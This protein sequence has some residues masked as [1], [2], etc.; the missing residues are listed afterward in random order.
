MDLITPIITSFLIFISQYYFTSRHKK[1]DEKQAMILE[2]K[3]KLLEEKEDARLK[4]LDEKFKVRKEEMVLIFDLLRAS[5]KL[6]YISALALKKGYC[7]GE[8][9]RAIEYYHKANDRLS[10]F[11]RGKAYK[12]ITKD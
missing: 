7:N 4:E 10:D 6:T 5:S 11:I 3:L 1:S 9:D 8:V 2:S 12:Y